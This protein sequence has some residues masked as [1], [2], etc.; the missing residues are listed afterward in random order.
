MLIRM[1]VER[2]RAAAA[3]L[4]VLAYRLMA[5]AFKAGVNKNAAKVH[6]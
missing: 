6:F 4:F 5:G 1:I 3:T 2:E